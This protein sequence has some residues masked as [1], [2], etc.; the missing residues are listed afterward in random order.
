MFS[1]VSVKGNGCKAVV[2][3]VYFVF[4]FFLV[5]PFPFVFVV[6]IQENIY[7]SCVISG[8]GE[9]GES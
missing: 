9:R 1:V 3:T 8:L 7:L 6:V 2:D 4:F 5:G